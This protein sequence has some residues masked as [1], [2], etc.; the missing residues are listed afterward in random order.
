MDLESVLPKNSI[1]LVISCEKMRILV[2]FSPRKKI[3]V[4]RQL[5]IFAT[6]KQRK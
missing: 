1:D 3:V 5:F 2:D 4:K 6:G